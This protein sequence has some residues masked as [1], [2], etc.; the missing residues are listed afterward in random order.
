[1]LVVPV[2]VSVPITVLAGAPVATRAEPPAGTGAAPNVGSL[3]SRR[4]TGAVAASASASASRS[5]T[6]WVAA[7]DRT[8]KSPAE[9]VRTATNVASVPPAGYTA[10]DASGT[11]SSHGNAVM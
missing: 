7:V 2:V 8:Q 4:R 1:V 10:L 11:G 5:S 3:V 6:T 9:S